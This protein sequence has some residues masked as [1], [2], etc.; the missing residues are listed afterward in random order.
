MNDA[1]AVPPTPSGWPVP[2][3]NISTGARMMFTT[4]VADCTYM[5]GLK[6]P[7]PRRA[8]PVATIANCAASAGTNQARYWPARRAVSGSAAWP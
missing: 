6:S 2:Q 1:S 8:A 4:T 7:M 3:P 5:P